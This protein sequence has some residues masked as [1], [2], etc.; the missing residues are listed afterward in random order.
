ME[1]LSQNWILLA[2][3]IGVVWLLWRARHGGMMGC[4]GTHAHEGPAEDAAQRSDASIKQE[5][6]APAGERPAAAQRHGGGGCH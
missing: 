3:A 4:C 6:T 5:K 1:W 2:F